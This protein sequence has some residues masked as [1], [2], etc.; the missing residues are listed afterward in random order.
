MLPHPLITKHT[1]TYAKRTHDEYAKQWQPVGVTRG[2]P[3]LLGCDDYAGTTPAAGRGEDT[4]RTRVLP[5]I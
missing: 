5:S 3:M 4:D 1:H 2:P